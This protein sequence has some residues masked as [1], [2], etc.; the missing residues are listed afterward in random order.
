MPFLN[1]RCAS[2][3][4]STDRYGTAESHSP[5]AYRQ[6]LFLSGSACFRALV[7]QDTLSTPPLSSLSV[8]G[9]TAR[10]FTD[11][12]ALRIFYVFAVLLSMLLGEIIDLVFPAL[13]T[14]GRPLSSD[15]PRTTKAI[16]F[17]WSY[18]SAIMSSLV[19]L[20]SRVSPH[21]EEQCATFCLGRRKKFAGNDIRIVD[22]VHEGCPCCC[23]LNIHD[24]GRYP[25]S[26]R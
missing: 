10:L 25:G 20:L 18:S 6:R 24:D 12:H 26:L 9:R 22:G 19:V 2:L 5:T 7:A 3:S 17:P 11:R 21:A 8:D 13:S 14:R 4:A 23:P 1:D 15:F 16:P